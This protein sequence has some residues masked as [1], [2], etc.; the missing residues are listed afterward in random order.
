M[1]YRAACRKANAEIN[2]SRLAYYTARLAEA[3]GEQRT[4]W[5]TAKELLHSSNRQPDVCPPEAAK[6]CDGFA[7]YFAEKLGRIADT[8]RTLMQSAPPYHLHPMRRHLP[9]KLCILSGVTVD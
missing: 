9:D 7:K 2:A 8:V 6:R 3:A 1:A 4:M 5:R